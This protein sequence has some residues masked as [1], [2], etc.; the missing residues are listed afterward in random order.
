MYVK[1]SI[2]TVYYNRED[3]ID[4]S[5]SSI[6]EQLTPE[7]ELIIIDD[8]STDRTYERLCKYSSSNVKVINKKNSGFTDSIKKAIDLCK[9]EY[10]A[11]HG[12]GDFSLEGRFAEQEKCLDLNPQI[13]LCSSLV[14]TINSKDDQENKIVTGT[15]FSG[16][17]TSTLLKKNFIVHGSVMF[18]KSLYENVGGY[19]S[20]FEFAQD[21]DLWIR[22]SRVCDFLILDSVL[23]S[24]YKM[25]EG[26]V[27]ISPEKIFKQRI[28]S[29]YA[30]ELHKHFIKHSVDLDFK[31]GLLSSYLLKPSLMTQIENIKVYFSISKRFGLQESERFLLLIKNSCLMAIVKF[32]S[33]ALY[34]VGKLRD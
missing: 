4:E 7:R 11:V 28:F 1:T 10:I 17:A 25:V 19:R 21:R 27:S 9:G 16:S 30:V 24:K 6:T 34:C 20:S 12:S 29:N 5:I 31:Y 22:M 14:E 15:A 23:Y 3:L 2:V 33:K 32:I 8:G 13:G 26:S 18:R